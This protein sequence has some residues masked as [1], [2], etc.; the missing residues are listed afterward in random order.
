M[1]SVIAL[2]RSLPASAPNTTDVRERSNG[3]SAYPA[4]ASARDA[5]SSA[6]SC[7]GSMLAN[8]VGGMP[9]R[10]GSNGI[11]G[12]KPPQREGVRSPLPS[13]A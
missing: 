5:A 11:S 2:D 9:Y 3:R 4:S 8:D 7:T 1:R 6:S 13:G 10:N 12:R